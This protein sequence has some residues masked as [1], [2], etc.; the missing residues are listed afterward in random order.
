VSWDLRGNGSLETE[1]AEAEVEVHGRAIAFALR[2]AESGVAVVEV[3]RKLVVTEQTFYRRKRRCA[4]QGVTKLENA[5]E[6][7][8]DVW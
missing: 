5:P 2:Q 8:H 6:G 1:K 3:C 7:R 4:R